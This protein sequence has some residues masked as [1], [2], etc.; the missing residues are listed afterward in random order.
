MKLKI[1]NSRLLHT[2]IFSL[3]TPLFFFVLMSLSKGTSAKNFSSFK[4]FASSHLLYLFVAILCA[5]LVFMAKKSSIATMMILIIWS[6]IF[7]VQ[8]FIYSF[9]K[10]VLTLIVLFCVTSFMML[11]IWRMELVE[12]YY[13]PQFKKSDLWPSA[14]KIFDAKLEYEGKITPVVLT[15][16]QEGSCFV[17]CEEKISHRSKNLLL[18]MRFD[19]VKFTSQAQLISTF[20]QGLGLKILR[21]VE[22]GKITQSPTWLDFYRIIEDRGY[23]PI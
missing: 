1:R 12:A 2:C 20:G 7:M 15:N 13:N 3:L 23:Q 22:K 18:T 14:R 6:T 21:T 9:D 17:L 11:N 4:I 8:E 16:W 5:L 19:D 10:G